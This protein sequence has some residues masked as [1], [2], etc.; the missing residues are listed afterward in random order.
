MSTIRVD[1]KAYGAI[2][3]DERQKILFPYGILG[4]ESLKEYVLLDAAQPPFYWLQSLE[5]LEIAFVLINPRIFNPDYRLEVSPEELAEI[6]IHSPEEALD[7]AI[8]TIPEDP[9]EMTANLQG[10]IVIN[11][12]SRTG[13][14]SISTNPRRE[15]RHPILKEL[16][17]TRKK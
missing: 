8:V 7:F 5:V 6:G 12:V 1:T 9:R 3:V 11:R 15:L 2:E 17:L 13:R 10:P 4:F 16:A 14:Q